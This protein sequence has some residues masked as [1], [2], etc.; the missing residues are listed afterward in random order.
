MFNVPLSAH[1]A[2]VGPEF[3]RSEN[4]ALR[5][6]ASALRSEGHRPTLVPLTAPADFERA[7]LEVIRCEPD[8]VGISIA[9]EGSAWLH[10]AL[11]MRL[12]ELGFRGPIVAGGAFAT[13]HAEELMHAS[14]AL[15][16]VV[17]H[18]GERAIVRLA[19][20]S[21][22]RGLIAEV[23]GIEWRDGEQVVP[24]APCD[25]SKVN[26]W[27][28]RGPD[29]LPAH[30]GIPAANMV[31]SRGCDRSCGYCCVAALRADARKRG[32]DFGQVG[33]PWMVRRRTVDDIAD[34]MA[35]LAY[36]F[37]AR[38]FEFQDDSFLPDDPDESV[39][40]VSE[41][42]DALERREVH[43]RAV[44]L[45]LRSDQVTRELCAELAR[46]GVVRAFVGVEAL[47]R[48][49][50]R[51]LG[52]HP[53][54]VPTRASLGRLRRL[55]IATYFNSLCIGPEA[56][57]SDVEHEVAALSEVRGV[58]FEIVRVAVYGGTAL[59]RRLREDGRLDGCGFLRRYRFNDDRVAVLA[60]AMARIETRH[61]G[62]RC[63]AKRVADLAYN[64]A[65]A[66]RFHPRSQ[67]GGI[68]RTTA[69]LVSRVNA[70]QVR[71]TSALV[72]LVQAGATA[73]S[74]EMDNVV[75][76]AMRRDVEAMHAIGSVA[77]ALEREVTLDGI[78]GPRAYF[79]GQVAAPLMASA[80]MALAG[81]GG[82]AVAEG[83]SGGAD[84][85]EA[86]HDA[87]LDASTDVD[88][89]VV[90]DVEDEPQEASASC[91][92][93]SATLCVESHPPVDPGLSERVMFK[94]ELMQKCGEYGYFKATVQVSEQGCGTLTVLQGAGGPFDPTSAVFQCVAD[95]LSHY[96]L[97]CF[98]GETIVFEDPGPM[99]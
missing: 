68:E 69:R 41:L 51:R 27:P 87:S 28:W 94:T 26:V 43:D 32:A 77:E 5:V 22:G 13:L 99:D 73:S 9:Y 64:L 1:V 17:R 61:F 39:L 98:A 49:M 2:L 6:L 70:E 89:D 42:I 93:L 31:A 23:P 33:L 65:L 50:N 45:K 56:D 37:G 59:E 58:P 24:G 52:R 3:E 78:V 55:G 66:K 83:P 18:D 15:D 4:L 38:I 95:L 90:F 12:R 67:L 44:V 10:A 29:A 46:L 53:S 19:E 60:E 97:A 47:T 76:G 81:C 92:V 25:F 36:E 40:F 71:C 82:T 8:A 30:L 86:G 75:L 88:I 34:E 84:A 16:G 21:V 35:S 7:A 80:F 72:A 14:P 63:P 11:P 74:P 96:N 91:E 85:A 57:L 20:S 54:A 79:R 48:R 62:K